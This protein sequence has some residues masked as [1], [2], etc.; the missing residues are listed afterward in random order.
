MMSWI[1]VGIGGFFGAI[2]RFFINNVTKE[3]Y[4]THFPYGTL[5]VNIF[6]S[7]LLGLLYGAQVS[8]AWML[9][10]G[11]GFLGAFTTFSTFKLEV[12][13]AMHK[14]ES[15]LVITYVISSYL[16]GI[17]SAFIGFYIGNIV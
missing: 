16:C 15:K 11:T 5:F 1:L 8:T 17:T 14:R 4:G 10:C 7:F 13:Q 12:V 6:G 3:K 2:A 9:L